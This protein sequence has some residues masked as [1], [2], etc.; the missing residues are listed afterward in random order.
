MNNINYGADV[1]AAGAYPYHLT[2]FR[3]A[4]FEETFDVLHA[5]YGGVSFKAE[6]RSY[7][8]SSGDPLATL[9][10]DV[11]EVVTKTYQEWIVA[12]VLEDGDLEG[13]DTLDDDVIIST[14]TITSAESSIVALPKAVQ[15]GKS[16]H[17]YWTLTQLTPQKE[18]IAVGSFTIVESA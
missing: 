18:I 9:S 14:L 7:P 17:L 5:D 4:P 13:C 12:C 16:T 8:G 11:D 2:A 1:S 15:A 3:N 10:V 6:I